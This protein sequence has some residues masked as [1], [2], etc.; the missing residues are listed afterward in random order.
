MTKPNKVELFIPKTPVSTQH[1]YV[2]RAVARSKMIRFLSK[3]AQAYKELVQSTFNSKYKQYITDGSSIFN[4]TYA[5]QVTVYLCFKTR[6]KSDWDNYHKLW[7]DALEGYAYDNDSQ[8]VKAVVYKEHCPDT[9]GL[10]LI[11]E[12]FIKE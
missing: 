9:P 10:R 3:E 4:N 7:Y 8:I 11:I 12:P 5:L 1:A 6:R 2:N